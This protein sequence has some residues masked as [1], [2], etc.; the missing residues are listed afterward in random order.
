M[1]TGDSAMERHDEYLCNS[2]MSGLP[3]TMSEHVGASDDT[4]ISQHRS[5]GLEDQIWEWC[6][7]TAAGVARMTERSVV[8]VKGVPRQQAHGTRPLGVRRPLSNLFPGSDIDV[9]DRR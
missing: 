2:A 9:H 5:V 4:D 6:A 1:M 3:A 8:G 7:R